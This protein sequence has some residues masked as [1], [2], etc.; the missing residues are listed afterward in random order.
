[1]G[2]TN[3]AAKL[4]GITGAYDSKFDRSQRE[5]RNNSINSSLRLPGDCDSSL[6]YV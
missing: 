3:A 4:C 5:Q 2:N 6:L 1:V